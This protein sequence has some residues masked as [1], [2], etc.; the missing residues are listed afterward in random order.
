VKVSLKYLHGWDGFM[1]SSFNTKNAISFLDTTYER[2]H[3]LGMQER[4]SEYEAGKMSFLQH[5]F[6]TLKQTYG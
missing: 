3:I 2:Y 1:V 5:K 6:S 4:Q